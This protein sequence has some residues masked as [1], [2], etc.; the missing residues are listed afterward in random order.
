MDSDHDP[1]DD[2]RLGNPWLRYATLCLNILALLT[3]FGGIF[4]GG[5]VASNLA[6]TSGQGWLLGAPV[7]LTIGFFAIFWGI[8]HVITTVLISRGNKI[9]WMFGL[10][11][12]V[13]YL[14]QL[15]P[16]WGIIILVGLLNE[17]SRRSFL[18]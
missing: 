9:G 2:P 12:G 10:L 8:L 3:M 7:G 6:E 11:L 1:F 5:W 17:K 14:P 4:A 18:G 13:V 16:P 15:C